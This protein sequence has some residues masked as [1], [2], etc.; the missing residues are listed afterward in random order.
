MNRR[1]RGWLYPALALLLAAAAGCTPSLQRHGAVVAQPA[2][3]D[4]ALL[5]ADGERL[6]LK[7]WLPE[8]APKAVI[9]ALH[10]FNDYSNAFD[11]PGRYWAAHGIATYAYDQRGFGGAPERGI[12][13]DF[14]TLQS[15]VLAAAEAVRRAHPGTPIYLLGESMGGAELLAMFARRPVPAGV[16]GIV[17][18][19]PAVWAR[20]T[21]PL[22]QRIALWMGS[23]TVPWLAVRPPPG[24]KIQASDNI[25]MLRAL[26]RDPLVIHDTRI[27][28]LHGLTD[29]MDAALGASSAFKVPSLVLFGANEQVVPK[30]PMELALAALP[31]DGPRIA[32]YP[33]GWHMLLRD[34]KAEIVLADITAWI[35]D[36]DTPLPSGH[37]RRRAGTPSDRQTANADAGAAAGPGH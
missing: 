12:W 28:A 34:L 30:K 11:A 7:R 16:A 32:V 14:Q 27:D 21:M 2:L 6:P 8:N 9:V 4:S 23:Y 17:L 33:D 37:E 29:L 36:P 1:R 10:G 19:A 26:G 3:T 31:A 13:A 22:Y 20:D 15:D 25:E 35:A 18:A 5:T 24:I